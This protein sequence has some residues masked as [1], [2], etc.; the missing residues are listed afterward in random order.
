MSPAKDYYRVLGV[1]ES[2]TEAEIKKAYRGLAKKYHPDANPNNDS[3]TERFK[4]VGE[5]YGV[6]SDPE[7]RKKYD[8][9]RK[10]GAFAPSGGF[11]P[12][13]GGRGG[14]GAKVEDLDFGGFPG[15]GGLG[16]LFSSIFG[17]GKRSAEPDPIEVTAT[18]PFRTA[19][20]GG[21]VP[22]TIGVNEACPVCGGSG[23]APGAKVNICDE[24]KGRGAV[25]FGQGGFAVT[26][27]CPACRGRGK[28]PSESCA[29]CAGQGEVAVQKRLLV[30]VRPG[31]ESGQ[32]VRLKG[33]GQRHPDSGPPGD[34]L[35]TFEVEPDRFF[36]REGL[37][38]HCSVPVNIAQAMLGTK[39]K[40]RTV[41]GRQFV[42]TVPAGTQPGRR[43]RVRGHGIEKSNAKGDQIVEV[44]VTIP[45]RLTPEQEAVLK[46]FA[47]ATDL[48]Y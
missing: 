26:R 16:D 15:F 46:Q 25:T 20:L 27:P 19:V 22:V 12:R 2:A 42:L 6:L 4:E 17:K 29:Q 23:A 14:A 31:A 36:R 44:Q 39:I 18:I 13:T 11:G 35:V 28:I 34:L 21:K 7:Q 47:D 32:K 30:T 9:M 43:F 5:A 41:K 10:L 33:Q 45:D 40:V 1:A 24:C 3:A 8:M 38:I 48:K 37:D